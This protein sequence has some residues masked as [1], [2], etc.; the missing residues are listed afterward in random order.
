MR[1]IVEAFARYEG[2][3]KAFC[4][5]QDIASHT[6]DYWRRKFDTPKIESSAFIALQVEGSS[7]TQTIELHFPNGVR[8]MLPMDA[9]LSVLQNLL[10]VSS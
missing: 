6:L 8:A 5:E 9:P 3:K 7:Q 2:S 4:L 10:K 1:P